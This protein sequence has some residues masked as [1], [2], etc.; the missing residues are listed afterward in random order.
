M[1]AAAV[2]RLQKFLSGGKREEKTREEIHHR[3]P[4]STTMTMRA[5]SDLGDSIASSVHVI[6]SPARLYLCVTMEV[7]PDALRRQIDADRRAAKGMFDVDENWSAAEVNARWG[8]N[9]VLTDGE[10]NLL[11]RA[12]DGARGMTDAGAKEVFF[13]FNALDVY[14]ETMYLAN[15]YTRVKV[16]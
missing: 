6:A 10:G 11:Y 1:I 9:A 4:D 3:T 8:K 16:R 7:K 14:P 5:L 12:M 2:E 15:G 13:E